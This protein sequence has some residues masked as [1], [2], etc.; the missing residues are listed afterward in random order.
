MKN[1]I[2]SNSLPQPAATKSNLYAHHP[3]TLCNQLHI[4]LNFTQIQILQTS[5]LKKKH[6][7]PKK[8]PIPSI[9]SL[10]IQRFGRARNESS[11]TLTD[12]PSGSNLR[13]RESIKVP[14]HQKF[15]RELVQE[16]PLSARAHP[17][18]LAQAFDRRARRDR[19]KDSRTRAVSSASR[20]WKCAREV[21][22]LA[23]R[24]GL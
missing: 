14:W 20:Q 21:T 9:P 5:A 23:R 4:K 10:Q 8:P 12:R 11:Q 22:C 24:R 7:L 17:G 6:L 3:S 2:T 15:E 18:A 13:N 19:Q 1:F 16:Q